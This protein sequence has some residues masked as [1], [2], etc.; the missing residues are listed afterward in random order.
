MKKNCKIKREFLE[1]KKKNELKELVNKNS[2]LKEVDLSKLNDLTRAQEKL[3]FEDLINEYS[4]LIEK[5]QKI[6]KDD[7]D[8]DTILNEIENYQN[9]FMKLNC[10]IQN[11]R[12]QNE[13]LIQRFMKEKKYVNYIDREN[14]KIA[15][16]INFL[17]F[18]LKNGK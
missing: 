18:H 17:K 11:K 6:D 8:N 5:I 12:I 1:N 16:S 7:I 13:N 4:F 10:Q 2:I 14:D 15:D 9:D 3:Y